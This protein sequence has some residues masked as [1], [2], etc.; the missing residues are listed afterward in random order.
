MQITADPAMFAPGQRIKVR[1]SGDCSKFSRSSSFILLSF[2]I[3]VPSGR[4]LSGL[5]K[6]L[7]GYPG[8]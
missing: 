6:V 4:Y 1:I 2:A 7:I 5:G 3:L 8:I